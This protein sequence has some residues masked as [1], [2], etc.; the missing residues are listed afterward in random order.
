MITVN[1][2]TQA[3]SLVSERGSK[4]V[5]S[6]AVRAARGNVLHVCLCL[7]LCLV[8]VAVVTCATRIN[9]S[10]YACVYVKVGCVGAC[11][12]DDVVRMSFVCNGVRACG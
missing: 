5:V 11:V 8:Q 6:F 10:C 1:S 7:Y 3:V 4:G 9:K 12:F 2:Y